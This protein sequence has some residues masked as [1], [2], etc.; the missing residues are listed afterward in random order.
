VVDTFEI[1][2]QP[3]QGA[4]ISSEALDVNRVNVDD[5]VKFTSHE[6]AYQQIN[7]FFS[8]HVSQ[9]DRNDKFYP[10]GFN[11]QFDLE[12]LGRIFKR[13]DQYGIGSFFNWKVIAPLYLL[14]LMDS[15]CKLSLP[16]YKLG[17]VCDHFGISLTN[18]HDAL[19]DVKATRELME[20]LKAGIS[21][22]GL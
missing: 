4:Q 7:E 9:F 20:R 13:F 10:A 1:R 16:N 2:M 14:Y 18:C 8:Q 17:T 15:M 22:S 19:A 3:H 11:V 21:I 12:F 5:L 6:K